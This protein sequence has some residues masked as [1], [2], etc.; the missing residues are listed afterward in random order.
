MGA[1]HLK[2]GSTQTAGNIFAI[3]RNQLVKLRVSRRSFLRGASAATA[4]GSAVVSG[5]VLPRF[6]EAA[7]PGVGD[8]V[9]VPGGTIVP[10]YHVNAPPDD[11]ASVFNLQG[12]VGLAFINGQVTEKNLKTGA[13]RVLPFNDADMRFMQ[14]KVQGKDGHIRDGTFAF[15]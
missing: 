8:V 14:G 9:P 15:I 2:S 11:P 7:A 10:G 3:H 5:L 6:V 4:L 1:G 12:N 13:S